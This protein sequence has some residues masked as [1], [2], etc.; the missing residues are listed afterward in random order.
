MKKRILCLLMAVFLLPGLI[1][2]PAGAT[3]SE[4]SGEVQTIRALGIM[5]GDSAGNLNLGGN[6]TRAQFA[7]ML[8]NASSYKDSVGE[9]EGVS[10]FKDVNST[11]WASQYIKIAVNEG[12]M[13]GYTDGTFRP[14]QSITLE[15]ACATVLRLL[16]YDS[17]ALAGSFPSAQL[18]K[19]SSLGLRDQISI[20]KGEYMTRSD[21]VYL[22]YNTL[23]AQ[24]SDAKTYAVTLGYTVTNGNVD[25]AAVVSANLSG[26]YVA[27]GGAQS[28]EMP[29]SA[30]AAAV[31]RNGAA[32]SLSAV[33]QYDVY[34]Y[35]AG[36]QTVWIYTDRAGGTITALLP[37]AA[38]P[39]SVTVG[40]K[41]YTVGT[42]TAAYKLSS[43]GG[44][45]VGDTALLL[46]GMNG[47]VVD[48]VNG[49][50]ASTVY[51]GVVTAVADASSSGSSAG[52]EVRVSVGC[53]DGVVHTFSVSQRG[54]YTVGSLVSASMTDSGASISQLT[55][56]TL[57]GAVNQAGTK[58]GDKLFAG[59]VQILDTASN[60]AWAK[61]Y[62]SR[63]AGYTLSTD[64]IRYYVTNTS[65]EI[66][67]LL[68]DD[69]TGDTWSYYYLT[70]VPERSNG[71]LSGSYSGLKDGA[72]VS[73]D[74]DGKTFNIESGGVGVQFKSDGTVKSMRALQS[75]T[76]DSLSSVSAMGGNTTYA[77]NSGVQVY[78][79]KWDANYVL[80][81]YQVDLG[82]INAA[83]YKLTGW[84]D[85]F[86]STAG[87]Q[88]RVIIAE[89]K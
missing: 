20:G 70:S 83:D 63:L 13:T 36:M 40:A 65:G 12:W 15:Q 80:N 8:V 53:T 59:D 84:V 32:S 11:H 50:A 69:A 19:A 3:V 28:L 76:L 46:L 21:C 58:L 7:K 74:S 52:T 43:M 67:H 45:K 89:K 82:S 71:T 4:S 49:N 25:Y 17:S 22:F 5:T 10:L 64:D 37:S 61:I 44:F 38:A 47:E 88:V 24:T 73:L 35:N 77:L 16:G 23:T 56:K 57:T 33:Q 81:Y 30:S 42:A 1:A 68:L 14:S 29:F 18:S 87:K 79:R 34:Y 51:Y 54:A 60:G 26:P 31:Y 72:T 2:V 27:T 86:G 85:N 62:P 78:L 75:V 48:V 6:V 41:T 55:A 66:T 39:T 9:G